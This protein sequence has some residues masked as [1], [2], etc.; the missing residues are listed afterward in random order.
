MCTL[1]ASRDPRLSCEGTPC[2]ASCVSTYT[3][4]T[5]ANATCGS[6]YLDL[7]ACGATKSA[8]SWGCLTILTVNIPMPPTT[9]APEGC[10]TEATAFTLA[11]LANATAC[12]PVLTARDAGGGLGF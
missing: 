8:D 4:L 2:V 1:L 11:I 10:Q 5:A 7:L 3:D 12:G 9:P 6:T